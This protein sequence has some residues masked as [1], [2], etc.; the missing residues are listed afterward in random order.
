MILSSPKLGSHLL[1]LT[2][3]PSP[4]LSSPTTSCWLYV[5]NTHPMDQFALL[6]PLAPGSRHI[7]SLLGQWDG[8]QMDFQLLQR[9][10]WKRSLSLY[11]LV[12]ILP[13]IIP[14]N[15]SLSFI[16]LPWLAIT[17]FLLPLF[18]CLFHW[19]ANSIKGWGLLC[20]SVNSC[21]I[22]TWVI[23]LM[24]H[25]KFESGPPCSLQVVI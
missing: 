13:V 17:C 19:P 23:E 6:L 24:S 15:A 14:H 12:L 9:V 2:S 10:V 8:F 1:F 5:Q 21:W 18:S 16:Y 25:V 20:I 11:L 4:H 7:I 22:W 3:P